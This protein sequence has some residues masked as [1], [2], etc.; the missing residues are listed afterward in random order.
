MSSR[1]DYYFRQRVTEAELDLGFEFAGKPAPFPLGHPL[2]P[3]FQFVQ[4]RNLGAAP[5]GGL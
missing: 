4:G 1:V 5:L 3:H 2:Q